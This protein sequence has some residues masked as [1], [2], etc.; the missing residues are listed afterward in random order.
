LAALICAGRVLNGRAQREAVE[1]NTPGRSVEV[2]SGIFKFALLILFH[3]CPDK[4][5]KEFATKT[6]RH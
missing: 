3:Y 5:K 4:I 2:I 1:K 6:R